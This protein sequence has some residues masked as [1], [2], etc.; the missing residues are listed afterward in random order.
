MP[1]SL[2][3]KTKTLGTRHQS[4]CQSR[5]SNENR[6]RQ[7]SKYSRTRGA[8]KSIW[9]RIYLADLLSSSK[10]RIGYRRTKRRSVGI[11]THAVCHRS[12]QCAAKPG[13][14]PLPVV[15]TAVGDRKD[16]CQFGNGFI[17]RTFVALEDEN[18]RQKNEVTKRGH[19]N[20]RRL[21]PQQ[22]MR[23]PTRSEA[24]AGCVPTAVGDRWVFFL[25][26][27]R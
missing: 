9:Q 25:R 5:S 22:S 23:R 10:M 24:A 16:R 4:H 12:N 19:P 6:R 21:P 15:P 7:A 2:M 8:G 13:P 27:P 1:P 18:W 17:R 20:S 14:R 3:S 11:Q 26:E